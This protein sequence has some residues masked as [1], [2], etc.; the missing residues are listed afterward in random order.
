MFANSNRTQRNA[1][2]DT[3]SDLNS[4]LLN[5]DLLHELFNV[6]ILPLKSMNE[7]K[8]KNLPASRAR[9]K[10]QDD[11]DLVQIGVRVSRLSTRDK[12]ALAR[13]GPERN[14]SET[15]RTRFARDRGSGS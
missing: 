15:C 1:T 5:L 3:S 11:L 7:F 14:T 8:R 12:S 4:D 9:I 6:D 13:L 10:V 2:L